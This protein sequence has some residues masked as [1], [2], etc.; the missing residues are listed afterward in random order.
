MPSKYLPH[1]LGGEPLP[2]NSLV[3]IRQGCVL[4][5]EAGFKGMGSAFGGRWR[6]EKPDDERFL[7][8][9]GEIK[10]TR[11]S[12]KRGG[13]DRET[14]IGDDGRAVRERHHSDHDSNKKHTDP[15]DHM[16]DWA[17][18]FPSPGD[19]IN[20]PDGAPEFKNYGGVRKMPERPWEETLE[21]NRFKTI[22]DFK[23]CVK[24]GGEFEIEWKGKTFAIFSKMKKSPSSPM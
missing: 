20:Y 6:P 10:Y 17:D 2:E 1:I 9:L 12:G 22:S 4:R 8:E 14:K 24:R 16:I 21:E 3:K 13:Y 18:G 15:H 7:G 19:Q 5:D 11:S 23:W